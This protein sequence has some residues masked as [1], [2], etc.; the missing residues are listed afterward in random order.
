MANKLTKIAE[1]IWCAD[2]DLYL[3]GG[4]HFNTRMT[5]IRFEDGRLWL[6][7]PIPVKALKSEIEALGEVAWIVAPSKL[8]HLFFPEALSTFPD[9]ETWAAP[10][11]AEKRDDIRFD[12]ELGG[13]CPWPELEWRPIQG[14]PEMNEFVFYHQ[15]TKTMLCTDLFFNIHEVSNWRSKFLFKLVGVWQRPQQSKVWRFATKDRVAAGQSIQSTMEWDIQRVI[16][17]HG[18][19]LEGPTAKV[20]Y[21]Q[22]VGWMLSGAPAKELVAA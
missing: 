14:A 2:H 13:N 15:P 4:F 1:N 12:K 3:P 16:I 6:H 8:H 11:L 5:I 9:A 19:I 20:D 22:A 18:E 21:L 10:G 7:S 17:C